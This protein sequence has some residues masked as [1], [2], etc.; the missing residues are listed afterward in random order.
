[1]A[2]GKMT[3]CIAVKRKCFWAIKRI[4]R[5]ILFICI[6]EIS[7]P[8]RVVQIF[9]ALCAVFFYVYIKKLC[10]YT[11]NNLNIDKTFL[12]FIYLVF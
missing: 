6:K 2:P 7:T 4:S 5:Q 8:A 9:S 12:Y 1:M 10:V 3:A 11:K